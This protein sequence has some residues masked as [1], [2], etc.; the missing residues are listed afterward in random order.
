MTQ[1]T[2]PLAGRGRVEQAA[3]RSLHA[4]RPVRYCVEHVFV[5]SVERE[6]GR[7]GECEVPLANGRD[8][9]DPPPQWRGHRRP[10]P[11]AARRSIALGTGVFDIRNI[12][13]EPERFYPIRS[14][15]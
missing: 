6:V 15:A 9:P 12:L 5:L 1:T 7:T 13:R 3:P 11:A 10:G 2:E 8:G 14:V 4:G